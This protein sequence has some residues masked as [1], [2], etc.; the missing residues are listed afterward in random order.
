A[1]FGALLDRAAA[2]GGL[3]GVIHGWSLDDFDPQAHVAGHDAALARCA[4][5]PLWLCQ[6]ALAPGRR[7]LALHF[8]TRGSQAAGGARVRAPLAALAWGLVASFVNEQRRPARLVDL[9]PD[10]RDGRADAALLVRALHADGEETQYAVRGA[11]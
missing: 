3:D 4:Q 9:D 5:G 8:L 10:S 6:A 11:R 7:E 1:G 2:D